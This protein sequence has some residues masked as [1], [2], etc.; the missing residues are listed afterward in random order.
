[1]I[2]DL[3]NPAVAPIVERHGRYWRNGQP[4]PPAPWDPTA[5]FAPDDRLDPKPL[6]QFNAASPMGE[7]TEPHILELPA[8]LDSAA[9]G[10]QTRR[11]YDED[12]LL[13]GD[14]FQIIGTSIPS[15]TLVGCDIRVSG[16]THWA[17]NCFTDV[18]QLDA[19][20][21]LSS[22]WAQRLL[23]NTRRAVDAVDTTRYP[24]GCMAFRGPVDMIEAMM[25]GAAM[26]EMAV[27]RPQDLKHLLA[28]ITDITIAVGR[29]HSDLLPGFADGWF[30]SYR[31]WTPGR[32]I[33]LTLDGA[34]LFSPA[35]Y[36]D[37]FIP[38]DRQ[39]CEAF[40]TPFVHLHAAARQQFDAWLDIP[41]LG[42]QCV[43]DQATLPEGHNQ[44]IG[45]QIPELL[46]DF[47]RIRQ[48]KSLMLYGYWSESDLRLVLDHLPASGCAITGMHEEPERLADLIN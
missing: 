1:M 44:P 20:D 35:M 16:G 12:G 45:P 2:T 6:Y 34:C 7:T 30:N 31:L 27:E 8:I 22:V 32:T 41:N 47:S 37:L 48:R 3:T 38:F 28:R 4:V 9:F 40:D 13:N 25:G 18:H 46:E 5:S 15:E 29:A 23:E 17:E 33:T 42:L 24:F 10:E 26:C 11:R 39:I 43:V 21:P 14:Y 36:E 19:V